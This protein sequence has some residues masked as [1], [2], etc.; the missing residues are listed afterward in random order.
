M[1]IVLNGYAFLGGQT[2]LS[3]PQVIRRWFSACFVFL[4]YDNL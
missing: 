3:L 4:G 2:F 1:P